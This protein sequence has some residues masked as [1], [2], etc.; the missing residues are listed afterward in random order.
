MTSSSS[1]GTKRK[2]EEDDDRKEKK[3]KTE[4]SIPK[5]RGYAMMA[6]VR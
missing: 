4:V 1:R 3:Y 2:V 5:Y 6:V